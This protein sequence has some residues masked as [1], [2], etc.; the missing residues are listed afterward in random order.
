[1]DKMVDKLKDFSYNDDRYMLTKEQ[2]T[3]I[4]DLLEKGIQVEVI[5][6]RGNI[7][8]MQ[9]SRKKIK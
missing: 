4:R 9:V 2:V 1:V 3:I 6:D 7:K 5:P 8:L